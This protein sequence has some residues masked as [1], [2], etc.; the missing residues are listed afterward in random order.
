MYHWRS[1]HCE[2]YSEKK[3]D[4]GGS[5]EYNYYSYS[6]CSRIIQHDLPETS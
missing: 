6:Y 1:R 5:A 4:G 2:S 3:D